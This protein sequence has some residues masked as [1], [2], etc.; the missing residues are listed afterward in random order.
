M[1]IIQ[2]VAVHRYHKEKRGT[3]FVRYMRSGRVRYIIEERVMVT[4]AVEIAS[5][6]Q[7]WWRQSVGDL[8]G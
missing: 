2:W 8:D 5:Q 1:W 7:R 3:R 4:E 6:R